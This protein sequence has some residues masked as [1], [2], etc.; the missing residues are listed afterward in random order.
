MMT[1]TFD[2]SGRRAAGAGR[3]RGF[4]LL[5]MM[6]VIGLVALL[7]SMALP[8]VIA[9]FNAGADAQAYNLVSAQFTAARARAVVSST[10]AGVH[11]QL[12]DALNDTADPLRPPD[13]LLRPE[14]TGVC[15]SGLIVYDSEKRWFDLIPGMTPV[16]IPGSFAFGYASKEV[17]GTNRSGAQCRLDA[18]IS[19]D[20]A[21]SLFVGDTMG[22]AD[23]IPKFTTFSVV[24]NSLGAVTRFVNGDPIH[25]NDQIPDPDKTKGQSE[26]FTD[27][28]ATDV[29]RYGSRRLW[30]LANTDYVQDRYGA[31][32]ITMFDIAEYASAS[33]RVTY[34]NENA[35]L[36]PLNIYT[37]QLYERK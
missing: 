18:T 8:S 6:V 12:A 10:Y 1:K 19:K 4:T 11:V 24:F 35:Q 3:F 26:I 21:S 36:L 17:T 5:E 33:S 31:T 25:F 2:K 28:S 23:N 22:V 16:R 37:G 30:R 13:A 7:A 15:F 29:A 14:L 27:A 32:A 20:D 9:L 34:L